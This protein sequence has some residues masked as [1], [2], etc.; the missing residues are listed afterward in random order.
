MTDS[1]T[2]YP[3][4]T[5]LIAKRSRHFWLIPVIGFIT[6]LFYFT[7]DV[8]FYRSTFQKQTLTSTGLIRIFKNFS[9]LSHIDKKTLTYKFLFQTNYYQGKILEF[10]DNKVKLLINGTS[11]MFDITN[12]FSILLE[13]PNNKYWVRSILT[14]SD[15]GK[16]VTLAKGERLA[17]FKNALIITFVNE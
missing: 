3:S 10:T 2:T 15:V 8:I 6:I 4:T 14:P 9:F 17:L 12:D 13:K 7:L 16:V 5:G 1:V 11:Q